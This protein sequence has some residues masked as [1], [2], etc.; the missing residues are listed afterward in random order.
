[1]S[2]ID[3]ALERANTPYSTAHAPRQS[4]FQPAW[5]IGGDRVVAHK[6]DDGEWRGPKGVPVG[7]LA[8]GKPGA[9]NAALLAAAIVAQHDPRVRQRLLAFRKARTDDVLKATLPKAR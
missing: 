3:E 9:A 4:A 1:M 8:I 6:R 2:R 7:T 5:P